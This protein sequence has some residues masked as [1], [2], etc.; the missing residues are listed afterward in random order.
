MEK[1]S[2]LAGQLSEYFL[3]ENLVVSLRTGSIYK[4]LD[5]YKRQSVAL[6]RTRCP[7]GGN[8]PLLNR[9]VDRLS[10]TTQLGISNYSVLSYGVDASGYGF[11][12]FPSMDGVA[13]VTGSVEASELE[14]RFLSVLRFMDKLHTSGIPCEDFSCDSFFVERTGVLRF[15]GV[16][17]S[18]EG[19]SEGTS[20]LPSMDSLR[21]AAPELDATSEG[22]L[23]ADVF[24]LGILGYRLFTGEYPELGEDGTYHNLPPVSAKNAGVSGWV[25]GV[26]ATS[27]ESD[28]SRRFASASEMLLRVNEWRE[29]EALK[30]ILPAVSGKELSKSQ[31]LSS[32]GAVPILLGRGMGEGVDKPEHTLTKKEK[33]KRSLGPLGWTS[34]IGLVLL[35]GWISCRIMIFVPQNA[36][37]ASISVVPGDLTMAELAD[38]TKGGN[39]VKRIESF[40]ASDDPLAHEAL[41]KEFQE[42]STPEV[43]EYVWKAILDRGRRKGLVRGSDQLRA[44]AK[45]MGPEFSP[46]NVAPLL[47]CLEPGLPAD[48]RDGVLRVAYATYPRLVMRYLA[49]LAIDSKKPESF[50]GIVSELSSQHAKIKDASAHSVFAVLLLVP[51]VYQSF[52]E[53]ILALAV[54]IRDPDLLWVLENA[55]QENSSHISKLADLVLSRKII[56]SPRTVF[57]EVLR[58]GQ[59]MPPSV[60]IALVRGAL[61][62]A[63]VENVS[64]VAQ[65][66]NKESFLSLAALAATASDDK[67]KELALNAMTNKPQ[68]DALMTQVIDF[69]KAHFKDHSLKSAGIVSSIALQEFLSQQELSA[70]LGKLEMLPRYKDFLSLLVAGASPKVVSVVLQDYGNDVPSSSLLPLLS[71]ADKSLRVRAVDLLGKTN[72]VVA[73]KLILEAYEV[74]T[75]VDVRQ[76]YEEKI[77]AVRERRARKK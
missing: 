11:I 40:V 17:G 75:D 59:Q 8:S 39:S 26:I 44:W 68:S 29:S 51:E 63:E 61:G 1:V 16:V 5:K 35:I 7:L 23:R 21:Y 69:A 54:Q 30:D 13:I 50:Q 58:R 27:L 37:R 18:F 47:R 19:T 20:D 6:Y 36:E 14:R 2:R 65:W 28:P 70:R 53:D 15:I 25:D 49:A 77:V 73:L 62:A 42:A 31:R 55:A 67:V 72:D 66:L 74:E 56:E 52:L 24:A 41:L 76:A 60:V 38:S 10:R 64:A 34:L 71:S 48:D 12:V 33:A 45:S 9:F 4:A 46:S 43:R 3:I 22:T 32:S 57:L